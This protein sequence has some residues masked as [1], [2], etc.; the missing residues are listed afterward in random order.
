MKV[1]VL[2]R[3]AV[4]P[5]FGFGQQGEHARGCLLHAVIQPAAVDDRQY[6]GK[7]PVMVAVRNDHLQVGGPQRAFVIFGQFQLNFFRQTE[8][9]D[10]FP[11]H[12]NGQAGIQQ[13][14]QEHVTADA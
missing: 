1:D 4:H 5:R 10:A 13:G 11:Q 2:H 7:V 9:V 6:I 12:I 3:F 8:R 14:G